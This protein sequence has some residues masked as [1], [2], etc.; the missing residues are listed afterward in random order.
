MCE[1]RRG[2]AAGLIIRI[3]LVV[4]SWTVSGPGGVLDESNTIRLLSGVWPLPADSGRLA[5]PAVY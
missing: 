4:S 5:L 1:A 3:K 2:A